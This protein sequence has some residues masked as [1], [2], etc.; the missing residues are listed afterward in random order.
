M[1]VRNIRMNAK[2]R[3]FEHFVT[4]IVTVTD[5][6]YTLECGRLPRLLVR[7]DVIVSAYHLSWAAPRSATFW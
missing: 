7:L 4:V 2:Q 1:E 6:E 3:K 5:V